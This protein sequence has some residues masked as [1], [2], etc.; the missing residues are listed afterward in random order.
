MVKLASGSGRNGCR[1]VDRVKQKIGCL[2]YKLH[3]NG[4]DE[5]FTRRIFGTSTEWGR[6]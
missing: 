1:V 4:M 6:S 3:S 2:W 5:F